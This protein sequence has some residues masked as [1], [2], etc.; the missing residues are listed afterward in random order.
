MCVCISVCNV[1]TAII[2]LCF[3]CISFGRVHGL[4]YAI[5]PSLTQIVNCI[6]FFLLLCVQVHHQMKNIG[7][8][9]G[10]FWGPFYPTI[11]TI[12]NLKLCLAPTIW[13]GELEK[14]PIQLTGV[15]WLCCFLLLSNY[16]H[17]H[18]LC[19]YRLIFSFSIVSMSER[20]IEY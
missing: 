12:E 11:D 10:S 8:F 13:N 6:H 20:I 3:E 2:F 1:I 17:K 5:W 19:T 15:K 16:L 18:N 14:L 4:M 7:V 9:I